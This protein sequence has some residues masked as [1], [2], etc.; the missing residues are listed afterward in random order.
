MDISDIA[1][2]YDDYNTKQLTDKLKEVKTYF[3][4]TAF[5]AF[6]KAILNKDKP[7]FDRNVHFYIKDSNVPNI[8]ARNNVIKDLYYIMLDAMRTDLKSTSRVIPK[9]IL[10][11]VAKEPGFDITLD[12]DF[13]GGDDDDD[14]III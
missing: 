3:G 7:S 12:D 4:S 5:E 1:N 2:I 10:K 8:K 13:G 9:H 11:T 14:D 6:L